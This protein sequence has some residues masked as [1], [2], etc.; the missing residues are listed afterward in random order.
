[1]SQEKLKELVSK[2]YSWDISPFDK[3]KLIIKKKK[4]IKKIIKV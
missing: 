1:M 2:R 3:E 4:I